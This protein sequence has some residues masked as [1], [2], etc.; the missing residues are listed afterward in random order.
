S[1]CFSLI[2]VSFPACANRQPFV[3]RF[4]KGYAYLFPISTRFDH[5]SELKPY[6]AKQVCFT[7]LEP[8][9]PQNSEDLMTVGYLMDLA[10]QAGYEPRIMRI[11]DLGWDPDQ[12][13]FVGIEDQPLR[14]IFKLYPWEWLLKDEF[15]AQLLA[16]YP[17]TQW[18]EP[19]WKMLL[20]NKG[21]LHIL[22]ELFPNHPNLLE[23]Y[24]DGPRRMTNYVK[25]PLF[26]REG[27]NL[28]IK[29]SV[30]EQMTEGPYGAEGFVYQALARVPNLD[31]G[32][33]ILGSWVIDGTAAGLGIRESKTPVT[34]NLSCF[35][36][37][38]FE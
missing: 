19:I 36:P 34:D 29:T 15:A 33:P 6:L 31:G 3:F 1:V 23:C 13:C 4:A 7:Y 24:F 5:S 9:D 30:N 14:S 18:I 8:G 25:K 22:W 12:N 20:S 32:F 28:T 17:F 38:L 26:S 11:D 2:G 16:N 10:T 37:H 21:I 27:A 35:V